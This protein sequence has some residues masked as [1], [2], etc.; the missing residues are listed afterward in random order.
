[1]PK[2]KNSKKRAHVSTDEQ[3]GSVRMLAALFDA[4]KALPPGDN[5]FAPESFEQF[6]RII[7]ETVRGFGSLRDSELN[8]RLLKNG[9][10]LA[11]PEKM[12]PRLKDLLQECVDKALV[13]TAGEYLEAGFIVGVAAG[14]R[15]F[16]R[17]YF[18]K[19]KPDGAR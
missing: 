16:G 7:F 18:E 9:I 5:L 1:M 3:E 12:D 19:P 8:T 10:R 4:D 6:T 2:T 14:L 11:P 15:G 13:T 17:K